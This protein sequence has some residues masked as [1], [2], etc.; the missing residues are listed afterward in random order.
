[1]LYGLVD[2]MKNLFDALHDYITSAL[3]WSPMRVK[4]IG[5]VSVPI[6]MIIFSFGS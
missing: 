3:V 4:W 5:L 2:L 1:M 6:R